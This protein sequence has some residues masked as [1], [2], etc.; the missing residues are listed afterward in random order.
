[1]LLFTGD[2]LFVFPCEFMVSY[3]SAVLNNTMSWMRLGRVLSIR[4]ASGP[5]V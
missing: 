5:E 2:K 1:M 3:E 4:T